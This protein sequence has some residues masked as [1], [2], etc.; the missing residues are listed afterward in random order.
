ME[1]PYSIIIISGP[2]GVGEDSIIE[3]LSDRIVLE[4]V[5]T[6]TT[7]PM[8]PGETEGHPYFFINKEEFLEKVKSKKFFEHAEEYNGHLYGV[9]FDE[10]RRVENS[11]KVGIWKIEYKGVIKAKKLISNIVAIF[12]NA[13][14]DV[15]ESRIRRRDKA[16]DA[17]VA[18][19]MKYTKEWLKYRNIYD[20]EVENTEGRLLESVDKVESLIRDLFPLDKKGKIL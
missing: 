6:T 9:T 1:K 10:L 18:E 14:L 7:R 5:V 15:L 13:P 8:R 20:Y 17:Y 11:K 16:D 2:S 4:R 3:K 12:I 19:R